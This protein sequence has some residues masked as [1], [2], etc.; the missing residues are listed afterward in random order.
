MARGARTP[1][2]I[3]VEA[4]GA[5]CGRCGGE[6]RPGYRLRGG[7]LRCLH[8]A[9]RH[10]PLVRRSL[11]TALIVGTVLTAINQGGRFIDGDVDLGVLLRMGLT[12]C[13]PFIVSTSGALGAARR[14]GPPPAER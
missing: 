12:Y 10:P 1:A 11:V 6:L 9:L 2:N 5:R 8:C 14:D 13:V 7:A 4:R 3:P